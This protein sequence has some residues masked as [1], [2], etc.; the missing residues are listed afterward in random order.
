MNAL[1]QDDRKTIPDPDNPGEEID[2]PN[3]GK[4]RT[5]KAEVEKITDADGNTTAVKVDGKTY[6]KVPDPDTDPKMK[7]KLQENEFLTLRTYNEAYKNDP[8]GYKRAVAAIKRHNM[9]IEKVEQVLAEGGTLD[10]MDPLPGTKP[11]S[12]ENCKK[13]KNAASK[14]MRDKIEELF[15]KPVTKAQQKILDKFDKLQDL[16]GEEYE[17]AMLKLMGDLAKHPDTSSGWADMVETFSYLR[18]L[19]NNKAAY[20]P[21]A[22]NFPLGDLVAIS[23]EEIDIENDSPE[24]VAEKIQAIHLGIENRSIKKE[25]GGPSSSHK[26]VELTE[27]NDAKNAETGEPISGKDVKA[28]ATHMAKDGYDNIWNK[29]KTEL[30]EE[31]KATQEK[32]KKYG[33]DITSKKYKDKRKKS[34]NTAVAA[35]NKKRAAKNPPPDP[36]PLSGEALKL[37]KE[38]LE[39]YHDQGTVFEKVYNENSGTQLYTNEAWKYNEKT[40]EVERDATDGGCK[41]CEVK[42]A[43]NV[44]F[45]ASGKPNNKLPTRFHN[46]D[47]CAVGE[48]IIA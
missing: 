39:A 25:T 44:G 17:K 22:G 20:L 38:R 11:D 18:A 9:L 19:N 23:D 35:I 28:D 46:V 37:M 32:A 2:N 5:R 10:V 40:G 30:A 16:D 48:G 27:F 26:K 34:V 33:V 24:E 43:F 7:K 47:K 42:F 36:T 14:Q 45:S 8:E 6:K 3:Y 13:V 15:P 12:P 31:R 4:A 41:Q 21:S 29:G 1:L